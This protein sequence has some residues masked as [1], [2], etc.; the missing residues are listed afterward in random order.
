MRKYFS[1]II[2]MVFF[3]TSAVFGNGLSLNSIGPKSLG[4]G[5]AYI[6]LA[7]DYSAAY[8]NPAGISQLEGTQI[9]VF[10]TDIVPSG[11]YKLTF[12]AA[13]GGAK[14][15]AKTESNHYF[16]PNIMGYLPLLGGEKLT[17]GLGAYVPA[18]LGAEWDGADLAAFGAGAQFEWMSKIGVFNVSP[19]VAYQVCEKISVG[20][21]VNIFYGMMDMKRP[22]DTFNMMTQQAGEDGI[23]DTQY[24]ESGSGF[25]FGFAFGFLVKPINMLSLGLSFKTKNT[26]AFEGT[27]EMTNM[28]KSDYSR[29]LA[30]PT[31]IGAGIALTPLEKLTITADVQISQWSKTEDVITTEYKDANWKAAMGATGGD[32]MELKW[33][34]AT[35][36]RVGAQY[37]L[38][39]KFAFRA[40]YYHD[41]APAPDETTNIIFPSITYDA[42]TVGATYALWKFNVD[43]GFEYLMGKDREIP[44]EEKYEMPGTHGMNI[45]APSLGLSYIF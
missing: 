27:A 17:V 10:F 2:V 34:D 5:G 45:I 44:F 6:G 8:W 3:S 18:G 31:W 15:D 35:Q 33:D 19:A 36:I 41:P 43:F 7:N 40:G 42:L 16:S 13:M 25:G 30:W 14:V 21:A 12:P 26:V 38:T 24:E 20:A 32:K 1:L 28:P 4:M 37:Q 22:V 11:T 9:A 29:D 23:V 39:E